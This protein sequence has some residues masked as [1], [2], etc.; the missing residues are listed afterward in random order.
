[1]FD[2]L[3]LRVIGPGLVMGLAGGFLAACLQRKG[4]VNNGAKGSIVTV[5]VG[6]I[7][8]GVGAVILTHHLFGGLEDGGKA[9]V[10]A[11]AAFVSKR[12]L[13]RIQDAEPGDI[14]SWF[15]RRPVQFPPS[16]PQVK[17]PNDGPQ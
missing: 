12:L 9:G 1:M 5:L 2:V 15:L 16:T 4:E 14:L 11:L 10:E 7:V 3:P 6:V 8:G 13:R 17:E